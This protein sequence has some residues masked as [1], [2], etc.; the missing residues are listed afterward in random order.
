MADDDD[1]RRKHE[2]ADDLAR[3]EES[4]EDDHR[5]GEA[6]EDSQ[7]GRQRRGRRRRRRCRRRR[8]C[9]H[10]GASAERPEPSW[11]ALFLAHPRTLLLIALWQ[12]SSWQRHSCHLWRNFEPRS[13]SAM[14][15]ILLLTALS[16]IGV[17]GTVRALRNDGYR[18]TPTYWSRLP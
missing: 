5:R 12:F 13:F 10:R 8:D 16:A 4:G 1:D 11:S 6:E 3:D 15:L 9:G 14:I 18:R 7:A 17:V 2:G